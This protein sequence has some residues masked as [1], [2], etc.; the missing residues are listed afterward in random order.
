MITKGLLNADLFKNVDSVAFS[1]ETIK[2]QK[3]IQFYQT[4]TSINT[5]RVVPSNSDSHSVL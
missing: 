4:V 1:L 2:I 5:S 3:Y